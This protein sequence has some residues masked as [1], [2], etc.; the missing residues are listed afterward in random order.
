MRQRLSQF[1]AARAWEPFHT[2][3]NLAAALSVEAGELLEI[4]QWLTPDQSAAV[5]TDP[6]TAHRVRDEVADVLAYLLQFCTVTGVDPLAA[7]AAKIDR[8]ELRFPA[9]GRSPAPGR[10]D[11]PRR[12]D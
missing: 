10:R 4:F 8:N 12:S 9:P 6:D 3:K 1:A 5:M 11:G 2:P 7:L